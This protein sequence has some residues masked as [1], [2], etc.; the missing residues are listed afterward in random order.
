MFIRYGRNS[1][2]KKKK[3]LSQHQTLN[4]SN[5]KNTL[6]AFLKEETYRN[7]KALVHPPLEN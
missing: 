6:E 2:Q 1:L 7:A 3:N 4:K 5:K